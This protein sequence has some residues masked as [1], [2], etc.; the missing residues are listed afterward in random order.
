MIY[1]IFGQQVAQFSDATYTERLF[2]L[3]GSGHVLELNVTYSLMHRVVKYWI[4]LDKLLFTVC[5]IEMGHEQIVI[6]TIHFSLCCVTYICG[7]KLFCL[8]HL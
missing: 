6:I 2:V 3:V 4:L 7:C 8:V 5:V 1:D